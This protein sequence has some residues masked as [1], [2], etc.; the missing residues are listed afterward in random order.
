MRRLFRKEFN[1]YTVSD[2]A[3]FRNVDKTI[4]VYVRSDATS[5]VVN[6]KRAQDKLQGLND[7][8]SDEERMEAARTF[9]RAMFGEK[10]GD[11]LCEFYNEPLAIVAVC[12]MYFDKRLK[13]KIT[14]AQKK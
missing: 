4:S 3:T 11:R 2:I 10:E 7:Q 13:N 6:L 12:G 1:P 14:K 5:L 8:S 9:A